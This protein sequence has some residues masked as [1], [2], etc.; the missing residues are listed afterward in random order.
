[1]QYDIDYYDKDF[2]HCGTSA[3]LAFEGKVY[4][5]DYLTNM[6]KQEMKDDFFPGAKYF[7]ITKKEAIDEQ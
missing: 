2:N 5:D 4:T 6:A 7:E 3:L 1:M